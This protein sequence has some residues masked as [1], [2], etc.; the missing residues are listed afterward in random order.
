MDTSSIVI[1][2]KEEGILAREVASY[3]LDKGLE[4]VF[5]VFVE[6]NVLN[7]FLTID[8]EEVSDEEYEMIFEEYDFKFYED[9]DFEIE[10]VD[11]FYNPI[12]VI[13][14]PFSTEHG[15]MQDTINMV[16]SHHIDELERIYNI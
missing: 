16:I 6:D 7:L 5:K 14:L 2:E 11:G 8:K 10:E 12:W 1:M 4:L 3:K 13:K 15:E 9:H